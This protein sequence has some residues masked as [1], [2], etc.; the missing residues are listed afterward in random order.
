[1]ADCLASGCTMLSLGSALS[2]MFLAQSI[3]NLQTSGCHLRARSHLLQKMS[4]VSV[5]TRPARTEGRSRNSSTGQQRRSCS[6]LFLLRLREESFASK[7]VMRQRA[8]T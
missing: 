3:H 4:C 7:D 2:H 5:L 6:F 1:M 8:D